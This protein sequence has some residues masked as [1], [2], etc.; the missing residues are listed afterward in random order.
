MYDHGLFF[1]SMQEID[2]R[3]SQVQPPT[4]YLK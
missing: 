4:H 2:F 1:A 3:D